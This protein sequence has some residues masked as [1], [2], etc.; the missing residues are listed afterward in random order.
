MFPIFCNLILILFFI[1]NWYSLCN[2]TTW[3]RG[4]EIFP[5]STKVKVNFFTFSWPLGHCSKK[6]TTIFK[7]CWEI[8]SLSK[9]SFFAHFQGGRSLPFSNPCYPRVAHNRSPALGHILVNFGQNRPGS[10][11]NHSLG[12]FSALFFTGGE[13]SGVGKNI[14]QK[15]LSPDLLISL[16]ELRCRAPTHVR[17]IA[18]QSVGSK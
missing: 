3:R 4:V 16:T 18:L 2:K 8:K 6:S 7:K 12:V 17:D 14:C 1:F 13:P 9:N 11:L 5:P 15:V 10:S